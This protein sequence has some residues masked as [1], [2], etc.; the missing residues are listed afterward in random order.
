MDRLRDGLQALLDGASALWN[1]ATNGSAVRQ[2]L[3]AIGG[4]LIIVLISGGVVFASLAPG[5]APQQVAQRAESTATATLTPTIKPTVKPTRKPTAKPTARPKP[6]P[7][8]TLPPPPPIPTQPPKPPTPKP[9]SGGTV[10]IGDSMFSQFCSQSTTSATPTATTASAT[11]TTTTTPTATPN[12]VPCPYYANNNPS[13]SQIA[14]ALA[15]AAAK[16]G[17]PVNMLKAVAWQESHWHNDV[18]SCDGG[19][20]LMQVQ[21][22]VYSWLNSVSIPSATGCY[23][24]QTTDNPYTLQGNAD[25]GAKYLKYLY[26]YYSFWGSYNYDINGNPHTLSNP[27]KWTVAWYYQQ[28]KLPYP[29]SS[30]PNS[31]CA[32]VFNQNSYYPA[33]PSTTSDPWSCPFS[34]TAGDT[35]LLDIT[36]SAYNEGPGAISQYGINNMNFYVIPVEGYIPQFAS[37]ALP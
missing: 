27:S 18:Y 34:A 32:S 23:M 1:R 7:V 8:P 9:S 30:L 37:G 3:F 2:R 13:Q 33:L 29:D 36:I 15:T 17:L 35:T 12:C 25:L 10:V 16:Y 19:I 6:K 31:L 14:S 5:A 20:G 22:Y 24:A 26:C 21:Y 4:A 28:A 11:T